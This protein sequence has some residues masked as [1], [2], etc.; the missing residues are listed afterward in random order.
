M[1]RPKIQNIYDD[2]DFFAGYQELR[3]TE[4]GINA[5]LEQPAFRRLLPPLAG[6]RILDLGCGF[7]HFA[8][9]AR[10]QQAS[11]VYAI[12]SSTKML[13]EA[14]RLTNDAQIK[15]VQ[16]SIEEF[17]PKETAFDLVV[18]SLALHYVHNYE[19][20]VRKVHT[21]LRAGGRFVFSVEHP[22]CTAN[23]IGW[24]CDAFQN[25][26]HWP[27]DRYGEEGKRSTKW[28]VDG[29][30]KFH[31]TTGTYVNSLTEAG[32]KILRLEEPQPLPEAVQKQPK[33]TLHSRRPVVL[34]LSAEKL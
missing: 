22:I 1:L 33:L 18:S 9:Y 26:L 15:Y 10:Q 25:E 8:R 7:G 13:A 27:L 31:R 32:F 34:L 19:S 30:I 4:S 11:E 6:L 2:P 17:P 5:A 20:V 24:Y 3:R 28:F 23:P 21:A 29:V 12:D 14:I 16:T